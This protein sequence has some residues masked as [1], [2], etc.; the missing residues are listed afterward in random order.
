MLRLAGETVSERAAIIAVPLL[1]VLQLLL[2]GWAATIGLTANWGPFHI[3]PLMAGWL[4]LW[5]LSNLHN[6]TLRSRAAEALG[7]YSL[8]L[9]PGPL[10]V[11]VLGLAVACR[12]TPSGWRI[13]L[14][15]P[16]LLLGGIL[17]FA[18][19]TNEAA[20]LA[21]PL[22]GLAALPALANTPILA[23]A[24]LSEAC[25]ILPPS[26]WP[27]ALCLLGLAL[28]FSPGRIESRLG[29]PLQLLGIVLATRQTG[30]VDSTL[31]ASEA[32][33]LALAVQTASN[34]EPNGWAVLLQM[35]LPPLAG[36]LPFWLGLH[37]LFGLAAAAPG[38]TAGALALALAS[39]LV[40]ARTLH[41]DWRRLTQSWPLPAPT[42]LILGVAMLLS[43]MPGFLFGIVHPALLALSGAKPEIWIGWPLWSIAG[44]D[45][46]YW[47]PLL[48][49]LI[50]AIL[51]PLA[52]LHP[53]L[54]P[55]PGM[56]AAW[57]ELPRAQRAW[58]FSWRRNMI[59]VR[60]SWRRGQ[61][62]AIGW[63]AILNTAATRETATRHALV[64][65]L[66]LLGGGL[67]VLGW[68][69]H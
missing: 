8:L 4:L 35:P 69:Q 17:P 36:F 47:Y 38:W 10:Q 22:P 6:A 27:A 60:R 9:H 13:G 65:W 48:V 37:A 21:A 29:W 55:L 59:S 61:N 67:I 20:L 64:L 15:A 43:A 42:P 56:R 2:S 11:M 39:G 51:M 44:G 52:F 63:T 53:A 45:G 5:T 41:N 1:G 30:L 34:R 40:M 26:F 19:P 25:R 54:P 14:L 62:R 16:A 58:P 46:G 50:P 23:F 7:A 18:A 12:G 33:M 49:F 68:T 3:T 24:L 57:P 66:L 31:A 28:A 32:L